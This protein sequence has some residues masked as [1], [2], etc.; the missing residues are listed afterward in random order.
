[1][2]LNRLRLSICTLPLLFAVIGSFG[3]ES[4]QCFAVPP[5]GAAG[6]AINP[7]ANPLAA[8]FHLRDKDGDGALT[9]D[10][11]VA[12]GGPEKGALRRNFIVFDADGDH[13]MSLNE[14]FTVPSGQPDDQR[15][16][17]PDPIVMLSKS[18]LQ[19]ITDDW[20]VWDL[21][22]D[23]ALAKD[24]F[25]KSII[26]SRV[27]GLD[28][29]T[30]EEWDLDHD[31]KL[32]PAEAERV[33]EIAFGV[34]IPTGEPVRFA[35]GRVVDWIM[36]R[37]LKKNDNGLVSREQYLA[38]LGTSVTDPES[39]YRSIDQN[40]DGEFD[41]LEFSHGN[42]RTDPVGTFLHLDID[43]NGRL[44]REELGA[45]PD[46]WRM[47]ALQ[48]FRGFDDDKDDA[49][50]LREYQFMPHCN[51]LAN[52]Q[53]AVDAIQDGLLDSNEF[54][55]MTGIPLAALS[56]EY[57]RRFDTNE[58]K[59]L[60]L[61][62]W[63]FST[64]H[65]GAKFRALDKDGNGLLSDAEFTA[66]GSLPPKRLS[67]DLHVFDVDRDGCLSLNEFMALPY[68]I[69]VDLRTAPP[70]P[71]VVLAETL[72]KG[73]NR[74]WPVWD[75]N[76]DGLLNSQ[77]FE[78]ARIGKRI[79]KHNKQLPT[80]VMI[81]FHTSEPGTSIQGLGETV[82]GDWDLD[83][84]ESISRDEA[85]KVVEI[86]CGVRTPEGELMRSQSGRVV[87][88]RLF[89]ALKQDQDGFVS[90]D[91]YF[92][93][94]GRL[95]DRDAW[96]ASNDKNNDGKFNFA[97][98]AKGN[99]QTDP[100]AN[101]LQLDTDLDGRL[102]SEELESL[103]A[104]RFP[105]ANF[106]FPGFDDNGD[107]ALSL[108]EFRLT[109]VMNLLAVWPSAKD[110]NNDGQLSLEEFRFH[111]GA[112]LAALSAEYFR[113]LDVDKND[114]LSLDE[115][116]FVTTVTP[117]TEIRIQFAKGNL[118]II[119]IPDYPIINSPEISPDKKWVAVDGWKHGQNNVSAHVLVASLES[120]EV[121]DLGTA[122]IPHWSADGRRIGYSKYSAGVFIRDFGKDADDEEL[123]DA[124]GWSI[125][126]SNDGLKAAYVF[127]GNN[128]AIYDLKTQKKKLIF[129]EQQSPF[130][131]IEHNFCW[132]PDSQRICFKG[133]RGDG[134][135]LDVG[136]VATEGDD[137]KLR[138]RCDGKDV[139]SDF[140]WLAHGNRLMFPKI[141]AN[142]HQTQIFE[143]N[144]DGDQPATRYPHQPKNRSNG[145][146]CWS[147]DES[148][149]VYMSTR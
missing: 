72:M 116:P 131:Y 139:Q 21:D 67:R 145:G 121:L 85:A 132:S 4:H 136:I 40:G 142:G 43:L 62:E 78:G 24:E 141:P 88:W 63:T 112:A 22:G 96:F 94:I 47:M 58:D 49:L 118:M 39:W 105:V 128:L 82:F 6:E 9:E 84:D 113:R 100:V 17:I 48:C 46:G 51:L 75:K 66:E 68:W 92:Q 38:A 138:V 99:H 5:A 56:A 111:P 69:P 55:F 36:F 11:Y 25:S 59:S 144:P 45:L 127:N 135:T 28:A 65:P 108:A 73:I 117:E 103:P 110:E 2:P 109:P 115:F 31:S 71:V 10:E 53:S 123:I 98:F 13:R 95:P 134:K 30:F 147:R 87:D 80:G 81:E 34:R 90:R 91:E 125:H 97:E 23:S 12:G 119:S 137:P 83:R 133:H 26:G 32:T 79:H 7:E 64:T 54:R 146:L 86:A 104:D 18:K 106:L 89:R 74:L 114:A 37:G 19:A 77:E 60:S 122:C 140:V 93:V 102:G 33:L 149:L 57:F 52:W 8:E 42:H 29:T 20:K 41:F 27:A 16:V 143:L 76:A 120:D 107:E 130:S 101:F 70:D 35:S 148:I 15:G 126:F 61:D 124:Q 1:M 129:P 44:S 3:E 50:S 14:F